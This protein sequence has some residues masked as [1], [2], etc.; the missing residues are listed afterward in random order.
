VRRHKAGLV[1]TDEGKGSSLPEADRAAVRDNLLPGI[2]HA[3]PAVRSQLGECAKYVVHTDYPEH[4]PALL[5][6]IV[7]H[8]STQVG[9]SRCTRT[10]RKIAC[11]VGGI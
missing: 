1:G 11:S 9:G 4:W 7:A 3:P 8:L 10:A 5:P 6:S 2:V